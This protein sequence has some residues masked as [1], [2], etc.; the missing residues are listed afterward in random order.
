M[1]WTQSETSEVLDLKVWLDEQMQAE[2][3]DVSY[4]KCLKLLMFIVY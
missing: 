3:D 4:I 1:M 2:D